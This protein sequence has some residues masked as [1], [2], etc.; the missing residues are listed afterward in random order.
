[1]KRE[2]GERDLE[3]RA[4]GLRKAEDKRDFPEVAKL[5]RVINEDSVSAVVDHD[6]AERLARHEKVDPLELLRCSVRIRRDDIRR[7]SLTPIIED[8]IYKWTLAY[9]PELLGYMAGVFEMERAQSNDLL[10][11]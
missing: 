2:L 9:D 1:M 8:E 10:D 4:S 5:Y 3:E 6:L 7:Y 11:A